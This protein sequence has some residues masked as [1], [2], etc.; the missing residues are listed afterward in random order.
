[1]CYNGSPYLRITSLLKDLAN[2]KPSVSGSLC[3]PH[4]SYREQTHSVFE[5]WN[6][7]SSSQEDVE[8]CPAVKPDVTGWSKL[9]V[10]KCP[11]F[12]FES[13]LRMS[14]AARLLGLRVRLSLRG[15]DVCL[16]QVLCFVRSLRRADPLSRG[17]LPSVYASLSV[18]RC[19][20]NPLY[21]DRVHTEKGSKGLRVDTRTLTNLITG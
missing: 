10:S 6:F 5:T 8:L 1:L 11:L 12:V 21:L 9:V 18:I 16:L 19:N 15:M 17:V 13:C 2:I 20:S 7:F 4:F 3:W 14:A